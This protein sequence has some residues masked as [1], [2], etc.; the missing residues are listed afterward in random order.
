MNNISVY[1]LL[2]A[3]KISANKL[4]LYFFAIVVI[5]RSFFSEVFFLY[6]FYLYF[7]YFLFF[8]FFFLYF[9]FFIYFIYIFTISLKYLSSFTITFKLNLNPLLYIYKNI[10]SYSFYSRSFIVL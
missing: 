10:I 2:I 8:F 1:Y 5:F 9:Y 3:I 7:K 4:I 6:L